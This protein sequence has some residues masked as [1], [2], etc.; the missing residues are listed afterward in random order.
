[1]IFLGSEGPD[2]RS[3]QALE[4]S[5]TS[6]TSRDRERGWRYDLKL[7]KELQGE[8]RVHQNL[9]RLQLS[10]IACE[11]QSLSRPRLKAPKNGGFLCT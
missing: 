5:T 3:L 11:P 2:Q 10:L 6:A 7:C 1:M 8:R 9:S 4:Q